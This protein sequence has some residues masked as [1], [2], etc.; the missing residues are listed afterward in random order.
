V[1]TCGVDSAAE[2]FAELSGVLDRAVGL[3]WKS[4]DDAA[5]LAALEAV[6]G[7]RTKVD[8]LAGR[9]SLA[10]Q[11]TAAVNRASSRSAAMY[12]GKETSASP[13]LTRADVRCANWLEDF[14]EFRDAHA[15][16]VLFRQHIDLLR[17]QADTPHTHFALVNA[18]EM[19]IDFAQKLRFDDFKIAIGYWVNGADPDGEIPKEQIRKTSFSMRRHNDGSMD[20]KGF[21]DPVLGTALWEAVNRES[22]KLFAAEK[23]DANTDAPR[24]RTIG[25][26][27]AEALVALAAKGS[28]RADGTMASPLIQIVASSKV[29]ENV[30]ARLNDDSI[31]IGLDY[32]DPDGR[33]EFIDGTPVHPAFL[34]A[35]MGVATFRRHI[36]GAKSR[37]DVSVNARTFPQWM[38]D[39]ALI[40]SRGRCT[41]VGCDS[42]FHWLQTDHVKPHAKGGE[43]SV[44]NAKTLCGPENQAKSD[45]WEPGTPRTQKPDEG[46]A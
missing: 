7:L 30:L 38:K 25:R 22:Q 11:Q 27:N 9:V 6:P 26:R 43:T 35:V 44:D 42:P 12:V 15:A 45:T 36:F 21:F 29:A 39:A 17:N 23:D 2:V 5:L 20:V 3:S 32:D 18:Q 1:E 40:E 16:G 10:A 13:K 41:S 28:L 14:A 33:C 4:L 31:D 19:L 37:P 24:Q 46:A 34:L 8:A